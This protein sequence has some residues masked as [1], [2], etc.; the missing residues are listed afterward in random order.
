MPALEARR[1]A[2]VSSQLA[3]RAKKEAAEAKL[4]KARQMAEELELASISA[5]AADARTAQH[6]IDVLKKQQEAQMTLLQEQ[7]Q[8]EL[9]HAQ[10]QQ[11]QLEV[12]SAEALT[13]HEGEWQHKWT[14]QESEAA[15]L[16]LVCQLV[17]M[18]CA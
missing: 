13:Q 18:L 1:C 16:Q 10:Q 17:L 15:V 7:H 6:A 5:N 3:S 11:Q 2:A 4:D 8:K 14:Q 12:A 9:A